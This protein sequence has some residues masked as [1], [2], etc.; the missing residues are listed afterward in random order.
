MSIAKYNLLINSQLID[1]GKY[2]YFP[3]QEKLMQRPKIVLSKIHELKSGIKVSDASEY[4]SAIYSIADSEMNAKAIDAAFAA[5]KVFKG[6]DVGFRKNLLIAIRDAIEERGNEIINLMM[7]E[8]LP[9]TIARWEFKEMLNAFSER[10]LS[11]YEEQIIKRINNEIAKET[12]ILY[13]KPDGVLGVVL[14]KNAPV[15]SSFLAL[16]A[17]LAGNTLVIKPPFK[18]PIA[19]LHIWQIIDKIIFEHTNITGV[20]NVIVGD[21]K[22]ILE[23]WLENELIRDILYFGNSSSGI[24]FGAKAFAKNKKVILELSGNDSLIV[25]DEANITRAADSFLDGFIGSSQVCMLPRTALI[26]SKY[27]KIFLDE[28]LKRTEN[29]SLLPQF[30]DETVLSPVGNIEKFNVFLRDAID[31]GAKLVRGGKRINNLG[32]EDP[33]GHYLEPTIIYLDAFQNLHK[34]KLYSEE[35][36][37]PLLT[38]VNVSG[39]KD[40]EIFQ[41][42]CDLINSSPFGLRTSIWCNNNDYIERF[43]NGIDNAGMIRI[44]SKHIEFSEYLPTHGGVRL[45]GGPYGGLNYLWERTSHLQGISIKT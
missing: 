31:R 16:F 28:A 12:I 8:G 33:K 15:S 41:N 29:H 38:I 14:P 39:S 23:E 40:D 24:E 21:S 2:E 17:L 45:T 37:F 30:S 35:A 7:M 36:F 34:M 18:F 9:P 11:F 43:I 10:T 42:I 1:T 6:L 5:F 32:E 27:A 4:I 13:R 25:W 22:E 20:V 3:N 44:N 19:V 26:H